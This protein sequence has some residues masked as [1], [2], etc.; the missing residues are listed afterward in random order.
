MVTFLFANIILDIT[1]VLEII[2]V[3]FCNLSIIISHGW[4]TFSIVFLMVFVFLEDLDLRL[5]YISR[6]RI[7]NKLTLV[8]MIL[9]GFVFIFLG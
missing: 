6:R 7:L 3:F 8:S 4:V 9:V 5:T 2:L 1:Q